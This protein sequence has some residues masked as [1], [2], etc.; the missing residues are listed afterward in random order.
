MD[1]FYAVAQNEV[2]T[3][4]SGIASVY[5]SLTVKYFPQSEDEAY[6]MSSPISF[7]DAYV[8]SSPTTLTKLSWDIPQSGKTQVRIDGTVVSDPGDRIVM[9][10][11]DTANW[12]I[13]EGNVDVMAYSNDVNRNNFSHTQTFSVDSGQHDFYAVAQNY[14]DKEGSGEASF[15][16]TLTVEF[17]PD[18]VGGPTLFN[19]SISETDVSIRGYPVSLADINMSTTSEGKALVNFNGEATAD[20]GDQVIMAASDT[21]NWGINDGNVSFLP[22]NSEINS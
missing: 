3:E 17:Y 19:Q 12:G 14:V 7:N 5:G 2:E 10:A 13:N 15:Y 6:V 16:G 20:S 8:R 9:A 11:S 1:T 21:A 18:Q 4:G 22:A